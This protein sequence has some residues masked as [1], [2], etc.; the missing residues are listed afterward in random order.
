MEDDYDCDIAVTGERAQIPRQADLL[1]SAVQATLRRHGVRGGRI[2]VAVVSD[3]C[4]A[5]LNGSYLDRHEPTD[6]L[7]FDLRDHSAPDDNDVSAAPVDGE[8]VVSLETAVRQ[9][10]R[11]NHAVDAELALY[12]VHG[13]L[14][15]LGYT[16]SDETD[17]ARMHR[18]EDTILGSLG[19][20]PVF[21]S[22]AS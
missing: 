3:A 17:A 20:G 15:L 9:A 14:H 12:A 1:Q 2:S 19:L 10:K 22:A 18:M 13:T 21:G 4:I 5:Q 11:R 7:S 8:I 6:V 16:D